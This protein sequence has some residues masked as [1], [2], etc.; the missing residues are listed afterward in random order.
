MLFEYYFKYVFI[1]NVVAMCSKYSRR[2]RRPVHVDQMTYGCKEFSYTRPLPPS[3][4]MYP[5]TTRNT[6][7]STVQATVYPF[8][9]TSSTYNTIT[10]RQSI[11]DH[12][13]ES[14]FG[15]NSV[16]AAENGSCADTM[17]EHKYF[18]L[19]PKYTQ[20]NQNE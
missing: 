15:P 13:Y 17:S 3:Y 6:L 12:I 10:N 1:F 16:M 20:S 4:E 5:T 7:P 11:R 18:V 8:S 2:E 14:T 9:E 19:D